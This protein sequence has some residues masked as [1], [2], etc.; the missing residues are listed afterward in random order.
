MI[1]CAAPASASIVEYT[2]VA[3]FD[4]AVSGATTYNF[5]GIAPAGGFTGSVPPIGGV[6]FTAPSSNA[7][8]V[9]A[10]AGYGHYGASFFTGTQSAFPFVN[11]TATLAGA[12]AIGFSYGS[13]LSSSAPVTVT[14]STGDM[15]ALT[16][17]VN[18]GVDTNFVGFTSSTPIT[19]VSF[20][21]SGGAF[22]VINFV[23]ASDTLVPLPA[24]DWL[25]LSGL[26]GLSL[27]LRRQRVKF[28]SQSRQNGPA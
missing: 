1:C 11:V 5:E 3:A 10:N 16:T 23:V 22:D 6:S 25:L 18:N 13:F 7:N 2:S 19:S 14:L 28:D 21:E 17:P 15:F 26:G 8:V 20:I 12:T 24:A 4:S 27:L 9:D